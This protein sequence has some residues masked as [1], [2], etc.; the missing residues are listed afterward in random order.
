MITDTTP[1]SGYQFPLTVLVT[2]NENFDEKIRLYTDNELHKGEFTNLRATS[3][4][5]VLSD[6]HHMLSFGCSEHLAIPHLLSEI[7]FTQPFGGSGSNVVQSNPDRNLKQITA[8]EFFDNQKMKFF[9]PEESHLNDTFKL[10]EYVNEDSYH[11][12]TIGAFRSPAFSPAFDSLTKRT[13]RDLIS[14]HLENDGIAY[15]ERTDLTFPEN[16]DSGVSYH[17]QVE[18]DFIRFHLSD[19]PESFHAIYPRVRKDL[20]QGYKFTDNALVVDTILTNNTSGN[21]QWDRCT[22][23]PKLIVSLYTKNQEPYWSPENYGLINRSIH[24]IEHCPSSIIKIESSFSHE[25]LCDES[26]QWAFFPD[27]Q[28]AKDFSERLF[29]QDVDDMFLQYDIVYPSSDGFIS[30]LQIHT[31]HVR[32]ENAL[33]KPSSLNG[34]LDLFTSGCFVSSGNLELYTFGVSGYASGDIFQLYTSGQ[35]LTPQSS[36]LDLFVSGL[37][38]AEKRLDLFTISS[39]SGTPDPSVFNLYASGQLAPEQSGMLDLFT[40]GK[41]IVTTELTGGSGNVFGLGM[42][43]GANEPDGINSSGSLNLNILKPISQE[44]DGSYWNLFRPN[45]LELFLFND[46]L[47]GVG[48]ASPNNNSLNMFSVGEQRLESNFRVVHAPLFV[49][50]TGTLIASGRM[51]LYLQSNIVEPGSTSGSMLLSLYNVH[52]GISA[53]GGG[54]NWDSYDYGVGI[55]ARDNIYSSISLDNEIRGVNTVGHG[56]CEHE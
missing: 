37:L 7:G 13:N 38:R 11:D 45:S 1:Y 2:Y 3:N 27:E 22:S 5:V 48:S 29:S 50:G 21:I 39:D 32:A 33:V 12:W 54:F 47:A 4:T 36:E 41:Q 6:H 42:R 30:N 20:P 35:Q 14:F 9:D 52:G 8:T 16:I 17:S 10:W 56:V 28:K 31:A 24:Y 49:S 40:H 19:S 53:S 26:E 43:V 18:N 55:D 34:S 51:P 25:D 44:G 23:G 15:G 46:H